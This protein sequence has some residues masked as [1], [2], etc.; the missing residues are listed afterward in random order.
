MGP[1]AEVREP[2]QHVSEPGRRVPGCLLRLRLGPP[3]PPSLEVCKHSVGTKLFFWE[4]SSCGGA[5]GLP[6]Q[7][8]GPEQQ[9][10]NEVPVL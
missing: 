1:S 3:A 5:C 8:V 2:S 7:R 6:G 10:L 9:E 4:I